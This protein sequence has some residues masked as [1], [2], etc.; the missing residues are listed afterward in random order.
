MTRTPLQLTE[1]DIGSFL[2]PTL[3]ELR[4]S[5]RERNARA[6]DFTADVNTASFRSSYYYNL[7]EIQ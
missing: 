3:D 2:H 5:V 7:V 4:K 1:S 6:V